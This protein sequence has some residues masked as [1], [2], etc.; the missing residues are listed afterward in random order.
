MNEI[1]IKKIPRGYTFIFFFPLKFCPVYFS[2]AFFGGVCVF[3]FYNPDMQ[4]WNEVAAY[5]VN[6]LHRIELLA[7]SSSP[8]LT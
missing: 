6:V 8:E 5:V 1:L 3:D 4:G 7:T 2:R